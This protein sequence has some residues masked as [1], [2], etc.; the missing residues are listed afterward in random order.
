MQSLRRGEY[1]QDLH[2]EYAYI[3]DTEIVQFNVVITNNIL[4]EIGTAVHIIDY[5]ILYTS[6]ICSKCSVEV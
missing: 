2:I 5:L 6:T 3:H 4:L 1:D